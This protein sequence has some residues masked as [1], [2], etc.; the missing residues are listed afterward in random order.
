MAGKMNCVPAIIFR[1]YPLALYVH[2]A[3]HCLNLTLSSLSSILSIRRCMKTIRMHN[4]SCLFFV[5]CHIDHVIKS[6]PTEKIRL[7]ITQV[8][9]AILNRPNYS[10]GPD[11]I[12]IKHLK[13]RGSLAIRYLTNMYNIAS[14]LTQYHIFRNVPQSSLFQKQTKTTTLAQTINPCYFY[15]PL[16]KH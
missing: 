5:N 16:P 8:Q 2:C 1:R 3:C 6:L 9:S 15:H 12:N 11:G 13:H 14:I 4:V 7:T 10:T